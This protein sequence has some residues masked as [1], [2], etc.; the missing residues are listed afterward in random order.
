MRG[1]CA[2]VIAKSTNLMNKILMY[3]NEE[4]C[5]VPYALFCL[6]RCSITIMYKLKKLTF[7]TKMAVLKSQY[8]PTRRVFVYK[9]Q[10][11]PIHTIL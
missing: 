7:K 10:V 6:D 5:Q 4:S 1:N 2:K 8:R 3:T 9:I 11:N